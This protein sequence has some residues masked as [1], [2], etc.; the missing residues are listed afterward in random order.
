MGT[1]QE[2]V[3]ANSETHAELLRGAT[4]WVTLA[5]KSGG[6]EQRAGI[7]EKS[8]PDPAGEAGRQ[9]VEPDLPHGKPPAIRVP[10]NE[11]LATPAGAVDAAHYAE[12]R[13]PP[14]GGHDIGRD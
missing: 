5:I 1:Q 13:S 10:L 3:A 11:L 9:L 7:D 14:F 6:A 8:M 12:Q 2:R 4:V